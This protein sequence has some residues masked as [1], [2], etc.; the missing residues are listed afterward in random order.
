MERWHRRI[1]KL[2][3]INDGTLLYYMLASEIMSPERLN[4]TMSG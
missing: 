2:R 1:K 4:I 3:V